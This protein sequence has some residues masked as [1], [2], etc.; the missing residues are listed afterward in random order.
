M[1]ETACWTGIEL[2][3]VVLNMYVL[4]AL[5]FS[6]ITGCALLSYVSLY[7]Q[8]LSMKTRFK[9]SMENFCITCNFFF[10]NYDLVYSMYPVFF[11]IAKNVMSF[12]IKWASSA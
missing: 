10:Y 3:C 1:C 12:S 8:I 2:Y 11:C 6:D 7:F 9:K 4:Y 5:C